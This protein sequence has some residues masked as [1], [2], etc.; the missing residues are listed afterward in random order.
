MDWVEGGVLDVSINAEC[1]VR[2]EG[3]SMPPPKTSASD[4]TVPLL[5][6]LQLGVEA[7]DQGPFSPPSPTRA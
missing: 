7:L 3:L 6:F 1:R 5:R 2:A 4:A